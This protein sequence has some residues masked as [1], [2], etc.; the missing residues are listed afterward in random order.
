MRADTKCTAFIH[1]FLDLVQDHMLIV[2]PKERMSCKG[3]QE[4]LG[5]MLQRCQSDEDY[6][7]RPVAGRTRPLTYRSLRLPMTSATETKP[8]QTLP[9]QARTSSRTRSALVMRP[10]MKIFN[11]PSRIPVPSLRRC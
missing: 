7:V 3:V 6:A 9:L 11:P 8:E 5:K 2:N 1:E 4:K 10:T